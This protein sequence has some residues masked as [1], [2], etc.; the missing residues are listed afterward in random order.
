MANFERPRAGVMAFLKI[1]TLYVIGNDDSEPPCDE[2][3]HFV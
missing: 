2:P 1:K 3:L